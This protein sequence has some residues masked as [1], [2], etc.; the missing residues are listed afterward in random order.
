MSPIRRFTWKSQMP[1]AAR[2]RKKGP[3]SGP[4]SCPPAEVSVDR[5]QVL[6]SETRLLALAHFSDEADRAI[7]KLRV[8]SDPL[9][10]CE[11][12]A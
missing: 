4:P 5:L 12:A 10:R 2:K 7:H 3:V 9:Q 11:R 1:F 6:D 8:T